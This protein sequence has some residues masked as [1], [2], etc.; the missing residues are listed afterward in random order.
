MKPSDDI[1]TALKKRE[2]QHKY[3]H[4]HALVLGG[5]VGQ[6][7][8][9]RLAAR[10][11]LRVGAGLVTLGVPPAALIENAAQLTSV[12]LAR[13]EDADALGKR[14]ED[15]RLSALCLGPGMGLG[16]REAA[17]VAAALADGRPAVLDADALTLVAQDGALFGALHGQTVLTPHEGEFTRLFHP[18]DGHEDREAA[19]RGAA[20][21]AGA[22]VLLKGA[23]TVIAAPDGRTVAL[24]FSGDLAAPW[25]ATAGAGDVLAGIIAGLMARG[26]QPFE[27][28]ETGAWLHGAA[29]RHL[30]AGLIAED[31]PE[32]LRDVFKALGV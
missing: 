23:E 7:G 13:V 12:M 21:R 20:E 11:A 5:G 25:L 18:L 17:L 31:L 15:Q 24:T 3:D 32:A 9:G 26:F 1:I 28:A 27:A 4:G 6:G 14:L 8:A 29:G 22:V 10:A 2:E 30:G 16:A 19:V